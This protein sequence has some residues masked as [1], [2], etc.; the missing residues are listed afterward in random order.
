MFGA[1]SYNVANCALRTC[2]FQELTYFHRSAAPYRDAVEV[3]YVR[4]LR[5]VRLG[6]QLRSGLSTDMTHVGDERVGERWSPVA[7]SQMHGSRRIF[8]GMPEA[9]E[10]P[11]RQHWGMWAN[12]YAGIHDDVLS[13]KFQS[14]D[15]LGQVTSDRLWCR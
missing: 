1:T 14:F 13:C 9:S 15:P 8:C 5:V 4:A 10:C 11:Y 7:G 2:T 3:T 12:S 6:E